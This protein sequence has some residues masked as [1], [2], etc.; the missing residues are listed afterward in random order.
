LDLFKEKEDH[1]VEEKVFDPEAGIS[2]NHEE[3]NSS[4]L[5]EIFNSTS[6]YKA[7]KEHKTP[8]VSKFNQ[9]DHGIILDEVEVDF[10]NLDELLEEDIQEVSNISKEVQTEIISILDNLPK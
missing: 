3:I 8:D 4:F 9:A 1:E 6:K 5:D 10:L 7:I 2:L